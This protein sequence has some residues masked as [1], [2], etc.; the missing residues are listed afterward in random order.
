MQQKTPYRGIDD[1]LRLA[2]DAAAP[3]LLW[4][5]YFFACYAF[6][7]AGC[8]SMLARMQW[9]GRPAISLVLTIATVAMT[10][11]ILLLLGRAA[12]RW[13]AGPRVLLST[14][15]LG[16][17]ALALLGVIWTALPHWVMPVCIG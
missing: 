3:L 14:A 16:I 10:L 6:V 1:F 9:L 15:R 4:L 12:I 2:L 11:L 17:A 8:A 13:H 5:F 7:A